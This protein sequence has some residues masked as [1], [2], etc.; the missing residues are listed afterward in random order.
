MAIVGT[1]DAWIQRDDAPFGFP[2]RGRQSHFEDPDYV[3]FNRDGK[4]CVRDGDATQ[5]L[6]GDH[7]KAYVKR[8]GTLN[9]IATGRETIVPAGYVKASQNAARYSSSGRA[10]GQVIR[11]PLLAEV[12]EDSHSHSGVLASGT[13]SGSMSQ[14]GGTS[15]AA[16]RLANVIARI[17]ATGAPGVQLRT[18]VDANGQP[19]VTLT[20]PSAPPSPSSTYI[21]PVE[22]LSTLATQDERLG[23]GRISP[24]P[25]DRRRIP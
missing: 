11:S 19:I 15:I 6:E 12:S 25:T 4:V 3:R 5:P 10:S 23:Y 8:A 17:L 24:P 18:A 20:A 2:K 14:F 1:I 16:P 22:V 7:N 9:A 13:H 21:G